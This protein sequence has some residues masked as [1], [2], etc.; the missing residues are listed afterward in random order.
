[1]IKIFLSPKIQNRQFV[2]LGG[3][4]DFQFALKIQYELIAE[5]ANSADKL[6]EAASSG[7]PF[8]K[9]SPREESNLDLRIRSP[10]LY[11]LSYGGYI[12]IFQQTTPPTHY[13]SK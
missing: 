9:V 4:Q 10:S 5:S 8:S 1:M 7:L 2:S 13:S 12:K 11:P 6:R 3:T